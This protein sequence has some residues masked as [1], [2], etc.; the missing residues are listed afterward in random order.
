MNSADR[1]DTQSLPLVGFNTDRCAHL[2][3]EVVDIS[4][5][6]QWLREVTQRG[7]IAADAGG[8]LAGAGANSDTATAVNIGFTHRG[9]LALGLDAGLLQVLQDL[10]PAYCEGAV[11]RAARR[12]GD[13]L[14][15]AAAYWDAAFGAGRAH[16]LLTVHARH[17]DV[18]DQ[19]M[20]GLAELPGGRTGLAGWDEPLAGKHLG[21]TKDPQGRPIR[22]AH[23]GFRDGIARPVVIP[24][25]GTQHHPLFAAGE[26]LLGY[27]NAAGFDRWSGAQPAAAARFFRNG[28][29]AAF[30]MVQQDEAGLEQWLSDAVQRLAAAGH[31]VST[32]Y[33]KAKLCGRWP[34][35]AIVKPGETT[36][37]ATPPPA[38]IDRFD[39]SKDPKG[40]GCPFG[41]H[42]RRTNPR[43]TSDVHDR[44][45][46]LFRRGI[47][48]GPPFSAETAHA[49][50]GLLGLFFC[51]SLEDQFEHMM[52]E[53]I[54][55]V[56]MGPDNRGDAKDPLA[57]LHDD[58]RTRFEIPQDAAPSLMIGGFR[59]FLR[60]RGTL[61]AFYPGLHALQLIAGS[62]GPAVAP[63]ALPQKAQPQPPKPPS[64][65]AV[66]AQRALPRDRPP[67]VP[68]GDLAADTALP[69]RY[70]DIIMEGGI[71][72]GLLYPPAAAELAKVYRFK[73]IGGS[74]VGAFAAAVTAAAEYRRR[75]GYVDGFNKLRRVPD[76][77]ATELDGEARLFW[78]FRPQP[79]TRRLFDVFVATLNRGSWLSRLAAV[80][81]AALKQYRT[82]VLLGMLAVLLLFGSGLLTHALIGI[83]LADI[84]SASRALKSA[85]V[86]ALI[87]SLA[88]FLALAVVA[89]LAAVT[90]GVL[91]DVARGLVPNYFG[92]CHGGPPPDEGQE[93]GRKSDDAPPLTVSLH[94][95]IQSCAGRDAL[96]DPPLTFKDLWDARGYPSAWLPAEDRPRSID[97]QVYATN[98]AHGRPYRFPLD[99]DDEMARLFFRPEE[100]AP[101]FPARVMQ[102]LVGYGKPYTQ[103]TPSDPPAESVG[104]GIY[105]LPRE[106]LPIVVAARMS[107]SFP[108]LISAVPL[109]AIDYSAKAPQDRKL[110]R[111]WFSDGGLC[112]NFPIHLFDSF[113]PRWPTF[114][115]TLQTRQQMWEHQRV[116]LP[117]RHWQGGADMR[118]DSDLDETGND[119]TGNFEKLGSFLSRIWNATWRWNDMTL[120]RMPGVRDRVVRVF[121][122]PGEG[123]INIR[124]SRDDILGLASTY[125]VP[126]A[127]AFIERYRDGR[128]WREH[129]WVRL[130]SLLAA[131]RARLGGL[132]EAL[133]QSHHAMPLKTQVAEAR[134]A[135]PL[136]GK[137]ENPLEQKQ[138]DEL[139]H[140][141]AALEQLEQTFAAA[142]D[143]RPF[144][145]KPRPSLRVRQP[146]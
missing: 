25:K 62:T 54:D 92:L 69:D 40:L 75:E 87:A 4:A 105:E 106:H 119:L 67:P 127:H 132:T 101:L 53:W 6:R 30:R 8:P 12:L 118:D 44:P 22:M 32:E 64:P 115:I 109:W 135:S 76:L 27:P 107:L 63:Q 61:Y 70:C 131:A 112:S 51:A 81:G 3:L 24:S 78:M 84:I 129:R 43:G 121:L 42:V 26:L 34:N 74:S 93:H 72:S 136:E 94:E 1:A 126:A 60:T 95:L 55:K 48:Y 97:L 104:Q 142:G 90:A 35:G 14:D 145:P 144:V 68:P 122:L 134:H 99:E 117:E 98:L 139:Q 29:F 123:G 77:L 65:A 2:V 18:I 128:G 59:P 36:S 41:S 96:A 38:D 13:T 58:P 52:G 10:A 88:A 49:D 23:F 110:R 103:A 146:T 141:I 80:V 11:A 9:L 130:N 137:C 21:D 133:A 140:L 57:G 66:A 16:V 19:R 124:M 111:C 100:L 79:E 7:W 45:R 114:G 31:H 91:W 113:V 83:G 120:M 116:W 73:S 50:R 15:S 47:P 37:P 86:M 5:A 20:A 82:L 85:G 17:A 71:T 125:G 39:F 108:L 33:L 89:A 102:H 143:T 28:S 138:V 56:P 46:P